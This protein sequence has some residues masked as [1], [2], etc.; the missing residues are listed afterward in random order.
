MNW[1][2]I[3]TTSTFLL[4]GT[5]LLFFAIAV[6]RSFP[7]FDFLK[8]TFYQKIKLRRFFKASSRLKKTQDKQTK[9]EERKVL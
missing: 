6:I 7:L 1:E 9:F 2:Q 5:C 4:S 8:L 3:L